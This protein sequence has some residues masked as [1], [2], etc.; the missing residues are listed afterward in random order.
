MILAMICNPEGETNSSPMMGIWMVRSFV[1]C[2]T[3][4][5]PAYNVVVNNDMHIDLCTCADFIHRRAPYKHMYLLHNFTSMQLH[6]E[7]DQ[8]NVIDMIKVGTI[9][10]D[11]LVEHNIIQQLSIETVSI[12]TNSDDVIEMI[13]TTEDNLQFITQTFTSLHHDRHHIIN[14]STISEEES[15]EYAQQVRE[16]LAFHQEMIQRHHHRRTGNTQHN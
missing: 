5:T 16:L 15:T 4:S 1:T 14:L 3:C 10:S 11:E 2:V 8:E 13:N 9:Q 7:I 12:A 6:Y